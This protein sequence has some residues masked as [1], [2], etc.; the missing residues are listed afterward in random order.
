MIC[1]NLLNQG[2]IVDT[3][4]EKEVL[5]V[6]EAAA[7]LGISERT[8]RR[9]IGENRVPFARIGGSLRLRRAALMAWLA[10]EERRNRARSGD[11]KAAHI[12]EEA[13]VPGGSASPEE[14]AARVRAIVGKYAHVPFSSDDLIRERQEEVAREE[15]RWEEIGTLG[16]DA[17]G[18]SLR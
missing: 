1:R 4:G 3:S 12:D 7:L 11:A 9:L 10:Q 13:V 2:D 8:L 14:R 6:R 17:R 15:R 5:N 18:G 16:T